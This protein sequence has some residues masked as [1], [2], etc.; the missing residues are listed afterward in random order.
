MKLAR[1]PR[2]LCTLVLSAL[3]VGGSAASW[4]QARPRILVTNDDGYESPGLRSL[5]AELA[6]FADVVVSAPAGNRSGSSQSMGSL[7]GALEVERVEIPGAAV[8]Y[9]INGTPAM[10]ATFGLLELGREK[11]FDLLVSGI[12]QGANVGKVS[13]LSGTVGAAMQGVYLGVP[14]IA[15]RR[16]RG[17]P[18]SDLCVES[19]R[20]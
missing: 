15:N 10:A 11:P 14:S 16:L 1:S 8:A 5:V 12:N 3:V 18:R 19:R 17:S 2:L 13:H 9:A 20:P 4:G 7:G 6:T